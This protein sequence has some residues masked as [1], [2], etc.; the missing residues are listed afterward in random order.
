VHDG[1]GKILDRQQ[2]TPGAEAAERQRK[3]QARQP[4]ER[5]HVAGDA[6][7]VDQHGPQRHMVDAPLGEAALGG[8]LGAAIG[9]ARGRR[10]I[11]AHGHRGACPALGADGGEKDEP[12]HA[13][14]GGIGQRQRRI[15]VHR[16]VA[17]LRHIRPHM[18]NAGAV[19]DGVD[20]LKRRP[21]VHRRGKVADEEG[22]GAGRRATRIAHGG[23]DGVARLAQGRGHMPADEARGPGEEDGAAPARR[24]AVAMP[25]RGREKRSSTK[26]T[27]A[28]PR[29]TMAACS[30]GALAP[31][32]NAASTARYRLSTS[33]CPTT[34]GTE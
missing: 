2:R 14:G 29:P 1:I 12:A 17:R 10:I 26:P 7:A 8:E 6:L 4:D 24:H 11:V 23:A 15:G 34:E 18:G 9:V 21:P 32:E 27:P 13:A 16:L 33:T 5:P 19:D 31:S 30:A 20:A 22:L 3:R 28:A 25:A